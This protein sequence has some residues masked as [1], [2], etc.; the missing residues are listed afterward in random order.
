MININSFFTAIK[1]VL[2]QEVDDVDNTD[3]SKSYQQRQEIGIVNSINS[4][5]YDN[6]IKLEN[7]DDSSISSADIEKLH[8][9]I[10]NNLTITADS[11]LEIEKLNNFSYL[12]D[13]GV[14]IPDIDAHKKIVF[15]KKLAKITNY[16]KEPYTDVVLFCEDGSIVAVSCKAT[17]PPTI[18]GGGVEGLKN[19]Y[20]D[21]FVKNIYDICIKALLDLN[22]KPG[23]I[24]D[25][26]DV[27]DIF[28]K[29]KDKAQATNILK[30]NDIIGGP[31]DFIYSGPMQVKTTVSANRLNFNGSF[32]TIEDFVN[33]KPVYIRLR[34]RD[35]SKSGEPI[36]IDKQAP[37]TPKVK[38]LPGE[39]TA[40]GFDVIFQSATNDKR[41]HGKN[42]TRIVTTTKISSK[43]KV[44]D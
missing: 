39:K 10:N 43:A 3:N 11:L 7:T 18:G 41:I 15:A 6:A 38:F 13:A 31:I 16:H 34:K 17:E 4:I 22:F 9:E 23:N 36:L 5:V 26:A 21:A 25:V 27:P 35:V 12:T 33:Y 40:S 19:I 24:Y 20:N 1:T 44:I 2:L 8:Q 30:G 37:A 28:I 32:I 14:V 29:I 42:A